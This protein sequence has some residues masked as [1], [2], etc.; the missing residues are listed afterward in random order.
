MHL[1]FLILSSILVGG[2]GALA[3]AALYCQNNQ[4][5]DCGWSFYTFAIFA[6]PISFALLLLFSRLTR[7]VTLKTLP[8]KFQAII[9]I[10]LLFF[11]LVVVLPRFFGIFILPFRL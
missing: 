5:P 7:K 1:F 4:N 6:V 9:L 2:F 11:L 3:I 8:R 10:I